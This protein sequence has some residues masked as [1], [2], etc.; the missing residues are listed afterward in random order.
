MNARMIHFLWELS[1]FLCF[2]QGLPNVKYR[3]KSLNLYAS[4]ASYILALTLTLSLAQR[5]Y[6]H[7]RHCGI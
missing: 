4:S 6:V 3:K 5:M 2:S 7:F 1:K